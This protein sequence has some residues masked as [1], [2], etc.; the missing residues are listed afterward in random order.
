MT[1]LFYPA[2]WLKA[3]GY[4]DSKINTGPGVIMFASN[5]S[6]STG[7]AWLLALLF[8]AMFSSIISLTVGYA[9]MNKRVLDSRGR[10][11]VETPRLPFSFT[12][13]AM[14]RRADYVA[15]DI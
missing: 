9:L 10:V 1:R 13:G 14:N 7:W 5:P 3:T 2:W 8:T 6:S 4:F 12:P 11:H 15:I